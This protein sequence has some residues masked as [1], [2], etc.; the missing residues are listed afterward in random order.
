MAALIWGTFRV[1][2]DPGKALV[3]IPGFL[4]LIIEILLFTAATYS[5]CNINLQV[6]SWIF[7][8]LVLVHYAISYDRVFSLLK[9]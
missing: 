3:P 8:R 6:V 7:G 1:P 2:G 4:R 5:L 9:H